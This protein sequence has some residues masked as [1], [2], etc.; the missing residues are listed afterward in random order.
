[1]IAL[2][3]FWVMLSELADGADILAWPETT[4]PPCGSNACA[5]TAADSPAIRPASTQRTLEFCAVAHQN[6]ADAVTL[7]RQPCRTPTMSV[8]PR[9]SSSARLAAGRPC[10]ASTLP[11]TPSP[12]ALA[13]I[14]DCS[15]LVASTSQPRP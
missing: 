9:P 14:T 1:M 5:W 8:N 6:V 10:L 12:K 3:E 11:R 15:T 13:L 7:A 4:P 2:E